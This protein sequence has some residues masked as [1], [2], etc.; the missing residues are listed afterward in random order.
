MN[1]LIELQALSANY[2]RALSEH[3]QA[4]LAVIQAQSAVDC[5]KLRVSSYAQEEGLL[6][7]SNEAA[8]KIQLSSIL[9]NTESIHLLEEYLYKARQYADYIS[10]DCKE[11]E[12]EISLTKAWLYSQSG[13]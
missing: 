9:E 6:N 11:L 3:Y 13:H 2:R 4:T 8:R 10:L 12:T 7:G 1:E 5:E